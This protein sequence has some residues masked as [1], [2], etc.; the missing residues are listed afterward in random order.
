MQ[1]NPS[2]RP[3]SAS[4]FRPSTSAQHV[5]FNVK[6]AAALEKY[7]TFANA[8][9]TICGGDFADKLI[10]VWSA[11]YDRCRFMDSRINPTGLLSWT[12][13]KSVFS[14]LHLQK[15]ATERSLRNLFSDL[16]THHSKILRFEILLMLL[17]DSHSR[18]R[19]M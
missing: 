11:F 17:Q 19:K 12:E 4:G 7:A 5:P 10:Q 8:L 15:M 1:S 3:C 14:Y 13:V 6:L 18:T 2:S 9:T 16:G